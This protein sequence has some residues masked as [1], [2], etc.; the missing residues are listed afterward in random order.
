MVSRTKVT[1]VEEVTLGIS[2]DKPKKLSKTCVLE[3]QNI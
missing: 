2:V 1:V 3:L